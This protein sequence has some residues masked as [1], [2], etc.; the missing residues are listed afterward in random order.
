[1][2]STGCEGSHNAATRA[3][4]AREVGR[5]PS[6]RRSSTRSSHFPI[7][8]QLDRRRGQRGRDLDDEYARRRSVGAVVPRRRGR[9]AGGR[10][11]EAVRTRFDR[12]HLTDG[13]RDSP[14]VSCAGHGAPSIRLG[15]MSARDPAQPALDAAPRGDDASSSSARL[16]DARAASGPVPAALAIDP[17]RLFGRP[18]GQGLLPPSPA[19]LRDTLQRRPRPPAGARRHPR[20]LGRDPLSRRHDWLGTS[21]LA[22]IKTGEAVEPDT[23][24]A[25]ASISKTFTAALILRLAQE[26]RL[27]LA[28]PAAQYLPELRIDRRV[29]RAHAAR[30]HE[31]PARLL[32]RPEDRQGAAGRPGPGLEPGAFAQVRRQGLLQA[33]QGLALLEH[34]LSPARAHRRARRRTTA[35]RRSSESRFF[36]PLDLDHTFEQIDESAW[37]PGRARVS[38]RSARAQSYA[39]STSPTG[40][41]WR[42]SR[43]WSP[44]PARPVRSPRR[45][46]T[47]S[48]GSSALYGGERPRPDDSRR[49]HGR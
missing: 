47:S 5:A 45:P 7:A 21:G 6:T 36:G 9:R 18:V 27:D 15:R 8:R 11:R 33:R 23:A 2:K 42:R 41:R 26:G 35:G 12:G 1:M 43:R 3:A 44:P 39:R 25:V 17:D 30:P 24:F 10:R 22:N 19:V 29:T 37:R 34:E 48:A 31:W 16:V 4:S 40:R 13:T 46:R 14:G 38:V 28:R 20:H 49:G 32:L